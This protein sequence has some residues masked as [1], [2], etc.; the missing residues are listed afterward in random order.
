MALLT[1]AVA[2]LSGVAPT[3]VVVQAASRARNE[4]L[5]EDMI[6]AWDR[7]D[8]DAVFADC[9]SDIV[10]GNGPLKDIVGLDA[11]KDYFIPVLKAATKIEFRVSR[12]VAAGSTVTVER[13]DYITF[14]DKTYA[15]PVAGFLTINESGKINQWR[16][17]FDA[18]SWY[19]QG[20]PPLESAAD[21]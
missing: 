13:V 17:Y 18:Q 1:N 20:G 8:I 7:Q 9:A 11:L 10:Y 4:T 21:R 16:D 12:L 3:D 2:S 5:V 6:D 19:D 14:G 15:V